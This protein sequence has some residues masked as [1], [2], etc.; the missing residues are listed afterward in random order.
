MQA[1]RADFGT[2]VD[3]HIKLAIAQSVELAQLV[4]QRLIGPPIRGGVADLDVVPMVPDQELHVADRVCAVVDLGDDRM[5]QPSDGGTGAFLGRVHP[6]LGVEPGERFLPRA[7]AGV[8]DVEVAGAGI[9]DRRMTGIAEC[10]D[11]SCHASRC[12]TVLT[13]Q[14]LPT[15][16]STSVA[17]SG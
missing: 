13:E 10:I 6:Y 12:A 14:R 15:M 5:H 7:V 3:D 9:G 11:P 2:G 17:E 1:R 8:V 4:Q 16:D